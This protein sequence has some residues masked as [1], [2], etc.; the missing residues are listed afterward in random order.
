[1]RLV[2]C[3]FGTKTIACIQTLIKHMEKPKRVTREE[4]LM[5]IC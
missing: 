1:M 2:N 5:E 3:P 4:K